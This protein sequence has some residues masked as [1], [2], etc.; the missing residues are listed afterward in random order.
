MRSSNDFDFRAQE[1][2]TNITKTGEKMH[3]SIDDDELEEKGEEEL[4]EEL[5]EEEEGGEEP[6]AKPKTKT[7]TKTKTNVVPTWHESN[8]MQIKSRNLKIAQA[9]KNA[10]LD[11]VRSLSSRLSDLLEADSIAP[12]LEKLSRGEFVVDLKGRD[13]QNEDNEAK[14]EG[15][16]KK[17]KDEDMG[18]DMLAARIKAECWDSMKDHS[19][20]IKA[21][22]ATVQVDTV[23]ATP[24][25]AAAATT[26]A[27][28]TPAS[29]AKSTMTTTQTLVSL[30]NFPVAR[31]PPPEQR[32]LD[33][34]KR[35]RLGEILDMRR[36]QSRC[37]PGGLLW[38]RS[39]EALPGDCRWV[40]N[41]GSLLATDDSMELNRQYGMFAAS[42]GGGEQPPTPPTLE[43]RQQ[44]LQQHLEL[45]LELQH[46][47]SSLR[48][49]LRRVMP[50]MRTEKGT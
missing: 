10:A 26:A 27:A 41:A 35:L 24:S 39:T 31:L 11:G 47:P 33:L 14:A 6:T 29:A 22:R 4:V 5:V 20:E 1:V 7:K 19:V 46:L 43:Q 36:T 28:T 38:A 48:L 13:R 9:T 12:P 17:I 49:R 18:R 34:V 16:R 25:A 23:A 15:V 30:R 37:H 8:L 21:L 3:E 42:K 50:R 40:V 32:K 2:R 44:H 45:E